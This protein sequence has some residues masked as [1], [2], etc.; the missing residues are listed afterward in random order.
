MIIPN[1]RTHIPRE[2]VMS[3]DVIE[4]LT[5]VDKQGLLIK[6]EI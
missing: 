1:M 6:M 2:G 3:G 5:V 4:L